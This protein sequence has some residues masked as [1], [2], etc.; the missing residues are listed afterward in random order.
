MFQA[1]G[2]NHEFDFGLADCDL[3]EAAGLTD[4][5]DVGTELGDA[6]G[7]QREISRAV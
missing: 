7:E 1:C 6:P 3:A 2:F 5:Q 4:L